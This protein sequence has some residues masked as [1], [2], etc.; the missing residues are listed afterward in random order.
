MDNSRQATAVLAGT[1]RTGSLVARKLAHAGAVYA[2]TGPEALTV[3]EVAGI[4]AG[5]VGR[6]IIRNDIERSAWI[7]GP[8]ADGAM[9]PGY[10]VMLNWLTATIAS[11]QRSRPNDDVRRETVM[12]TPGRG[13]RWG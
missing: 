10:R 12:L 4:I 1:A 7:D 9:P 5:A 3:A 11:G 2:P 13:M 6:S 8:I